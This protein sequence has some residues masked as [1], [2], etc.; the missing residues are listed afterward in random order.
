[1]IWG[2]PHL[3]NPPYAKIALLGFNVS[4]LSNDR[5]T[6]VI[7]VL[8]WCPSQHTEKQRHEPSESQANKPSMSWTR[9][10]CGARLSDRMLDV[11]SMSR[12]GHLSRPDSELTF[13]SLPSCHVNS[14]SVAT[15]AI[16]PT[17]VR[18][19]DRTWNVNKYQQLPQLPEK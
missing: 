18:P 12:M 7:Q 2:Y 14:V 9:G 3:W 4:T 1:M 5:S 10:T 15:A 6:Q 16:L 19:P 11:C 17:P 8:H 13:L